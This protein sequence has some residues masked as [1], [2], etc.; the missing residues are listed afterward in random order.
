MCESDLVLNIVIDFVVNVRMVKELCGHI[1]AEAEALAALVAAA[2]RADAACT[3][4]KAAQLGPRFSLKFLESL[5]LLAE[6]KVGHMLAGLSLEQNVQLLQADLQFV[7]VL[8]IL[9]ENL[10]LVQDLVLAEMRLVVRTL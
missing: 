5:L 6:L 8:A 2:D 1:L 10:L 3:A 9:E 7:L 4:A